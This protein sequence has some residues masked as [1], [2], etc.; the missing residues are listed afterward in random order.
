[1]L[2]KTEILVCLNG[3]TDKTEKIVKNLQKNYFNNL[4]IIYA[5]KGKLNAHKKIVDNINHK[6][7]IFF[8]DA[9][10]LVPGKSILAILN[11]FKKNKKVKIVSAYPYTLKSNK[12]KFHQKIIYNV[13][14]LKR[15][16]PKIEVAKRDVSKF[17]GK[18]KDKFL[19]RSRIYFHGRFFCIKNREIYG[20]PKRGSRIRGDDTF[21]TRVVLS[22]FGPGS[23][24]VLFNSLVYCAPLHSIQAYLRSWYRIR[25]DIDMIKKE[26][27]EFNEIN[28]HV[29]MT[30]NWE[31]YKTLDQKN[32][33]YVLLFFLLR[34]Y[35]KYSYL[36]LKKSIDLDTIW[37]YDNKE[38]IRVYKK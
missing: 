3:C 7:E 1:M 20:F 34:L 9:D 36:L 23:I 5:K 33:F 6:N 28:N 4:K 15:I 18:V 38:G 32:K 14:N 19:K 37:F 10:V 24:K 22:K 25:K 21:L 13:L 8:C 26:Y 17:H 2:K 29:E 16:H 12:T 27:P 31:Y 35:E 11:E 30:L